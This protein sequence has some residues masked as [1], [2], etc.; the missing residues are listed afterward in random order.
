MILNLNAIKQELNE[1][2][3]YRIELHAH[4][5]P[6]SPCSEIPPED[7]IRIYKDLGFHALVLTNHFMIFNYEQKKDE[8]L[9]SYIEAYEKCVE[10]G[11][12][13]GI[14]VLFGTEIRFTEN[15]NDYLIYGVN[16]ELLNDIYD[17]LPYGIE[18]FRKNYPLDNSVFIQ[19]HPFRKGIELVNPELLDGIEVYN[20]HPNHNSRVA[21]ASAYAKENGKDIITI[22]TDFHHPG[23]EGLTALRSKILPD[24]SFDLANILKSKDYIFEV[25]NNN[26]IIP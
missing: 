6:V 8:Y 25:A 19:A 7:L 18:N 5:K 21:V 12:R 1:D 13:A 24:D 16:K 4:S 9:K 22:G 2:Y 20:L 14:K 10:L 26:L 3:K 23:H 15:Q 11:E 17:F